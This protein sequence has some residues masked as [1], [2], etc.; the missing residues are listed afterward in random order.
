MQQS[1][2]EAL[3]SECTNPARFLLLYFHMLRHVLIS[4]NLVAMR[5]LSFVGSSSSARLAIGAL[6]IATAAAF[7][8]AR[9]LTRSVQRERFDYE[10]RRVDLAVEERMHAYV[11]VLRGGAGL[12][13]ASDEVTRDDWRQY[14]QTL[15]LELNYPGFRAVTF[16][17]AVLEAELPAFIATVRA[18][19]L[20]PQISNPQVLRNF[21]L[22]PPPPPIELVETSLH[23]PVLYTE[24]LNKEREKSI[25]IDMMLDAGRRAAM[26]SA[27]ERHDAVLSPRLQLIRLETTEV[28]FIAYLPANHNGKLVGWVTAT[29]Y[30]KDFMRGLFGDRGSKLGFRVYDGVSTQIQSLLYSTDGIDAG[31]DPIAFHGHAFSHTRISTLKMPGRVWTAEYYAGP[32]F[33]PFAER[34]LPWLVASGG[35]LATLLFMVAARAG[36][37]WRAQAEIL[38]EAE[39]AVRN[40]AMHDPLTG[41]ANRI[42]FTDRLNTALELTRRSGAPF[43]LAYIDIDGFK[44]VNDTHGHQAGDALLRAIAERLQASLRKCDTV[45]RLGGDEFA[46]I[47]EG[48]VDPAMALRVCNDIIAKLCEPFRLGAGHH[49]VQIGASVGLAMHPIHGNT[50][51]ALVSAADNA[52]YRAKKGG[53]NRCEM[54]NLGG[55]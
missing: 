41:L 50:A 21:T 19:P 20:W 40:Q 3:F 22:R 27:V 9:T 17:P 52:M 18:S 46:L 33:I 29:F 8:H 15:D 23:A 36:A 49:I 2:A 12:F 24:P 51:D 43:A 31:G 5:T 53:G 38:R 35:L 37:Q 26:L 39:V 16:A 30:P 34:A 32:E 10:V 48:P 47:I 1:Q 7:V 42:L 45:A 25:G 13:A 14:F 55:D 54:A 28:G 4:R 6:L 44:P 11:Q